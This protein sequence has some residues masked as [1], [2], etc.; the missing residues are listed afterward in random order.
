MS[1]L[2]N[3]YP[4]ITKSYLPSFIRDYI[5]KS[6]ET[7]D[8][9][10]GCR[11]YFALPP[12]ITQEQ[13]DKTLH[14]LGIQMTVVYQNTN[15]TALRTDW[16]PLGIKVIWDI[17]K[18]NSIQNDYKYYVRI[19][20][21]QL[22]DK[23]FLLN[24]HY[25]VQLRFFKHGNYGRRYSE[26]EYNELKLKQKE[27]EKE[28]N[29]VNLDKITTTDES[30][31][32][33]NIDWL[34][35]S[36]PYC[37]E[38]SSVCIIKGI[39]NPSFK[40]KG[41]Q[42]E[43]ATQKILLVGK[44][45]LIQGKLLFLEDE[46]QTLKNYNIKLY[47]TANKDF[48]LLKKKK[49]PFYN[50]TPLVDSGDL[51]TNY[52]GINEINYE[53]RWNFSPNVQYTIVIT[54]ETTN[55]YKRRK[56]YNFYILPYEPKQINL[57]ITA[58]PNEEKGTIKININFDQFFI[59]NINIRRT[60]SKYNF[61]YYE[62]IHTMPYTTDPN[63]QN[64]I[65]SWEDRTVQSGIWYRYAV[66]TINYYGSRSHLVEIDEPVICMFEDM[67]L[68]NKDGQLNIK[69][70]PTL[71]NFKY[72]VNDSQ[73]TALGSKYPYF[74]RN[75]ENYYRTFTIGGLI[76]TYN[77][78]TNW[79]N[80]HFY[81]NNIFFK[82]KDFIENSSNQDQIDQYDEIGNF[83]TKKELFDD[84]TINKYREYNQNNNIK[85]ENDFIYQKFFRD[86]VYEFLYKNNVKLFKS[87]TEGNILVKLTDINFQ[88][89]QQLGR[90]LYSF[91]ATATEIDECNITNYN[92]YDIQSIGSWSKY[93]QNE[94][95]QFGH[96]Q[97]QINYKNGN[98]INILS[99][100]Y[101]IHNN[102][103]ISSIQSL[104]YLKLEIEDDINNQSFIET[105]PFYT[106]KINESIVKIPVRA[107]P[108][109]NR[110]NYG[111]LQIGYC[112]QQENPDEQQAEQKKPNQE[113]DITNLEIYSPENNSKTLN[114][115]LDYIAKIVDKEIPQK[116]KKYSYYYVNTGQLYNFFDNEQYLMYRLK[117]KYN[118][119]GNTVSFEI[120]KVYNF[121]F[122][123]DPGAVLK[124]KQ[125][126]SN[127][128]FFFTLTNGYLNFITKEQNDLITDFAFCGIYLDHYTFENEQPSK[129]NI[130]DD[131]FIVCNSI[132]YNNLEQLKQ[133][134]NPIKNHVYR[135]QNDLY[136]Y[137]KNNYYP[138]DAT[139]N[140]Q[141]GTIEGNKI[142]KCP[143]FGIVN[144]DYELQKD[145][146]QKESEES[147][148]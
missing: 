113:I 28:S 5:K 27:T 6:E 94:R 120:K 37:S 1:L 45:I 41:F 24:Q 72:M 140:T 135:V 142:V 50:V 143:V 44:S 19:L 21:Q 54:Y 49:D 52:Y 16:Y 48:S 23:Q 134:S 53:L 38:W 115:S 13:A 98:I 68:I 60:S 100:K 29:I 12:S 92:I 146:Y 22:K 39:S 3:L 15:I 65:Y 2:N 147:Y 32:L 76:S 121:R 117:K 11:I 97:G 125:K 61:A 88:P 144:Y 64:P 90:R 108:A 122:E 75:A 126:N 57:G 69:L 59:G 55:S 25:K 101:Q 84:Y 40:I 10:N 89:N 129:F 119:I 106:I 33:L 67:F 9:P 66:Q 111:F 71:N 74:S 123:S 7:Y 99:E 138:F 128:E 93:I 139:Y 124:I 132:V 34:K 102:S 30:T 136:I 131:Q 47:Y 114:I 78:T 118:F 141:E 4:P 18:D 110:L 109:D 137:Y 133:N 77:D 148:E 58:I 79:Y 43:A 81:A 82:D 104:K 46:L 112:N 91:T 8:D 26:E 85:Q 14:N 42:K 20:P 116:I 107:N 36:Q 105:E 96:Y 80:P 130:R 31:L 87:T 86:K 63:E 95:E 103:Y 70:N 51:F 62:D 17:Q 127:E 83:T 73:Q 35:K 56:S 145:I